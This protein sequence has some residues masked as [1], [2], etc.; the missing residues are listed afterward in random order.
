MALPLIISLVSFPS[1][2]LSLLTCKEGTVGVPTSL[3]WSEGYTVSTCKPG[4]ASRKMCFRPLPLEW[5]PH[6]AG[7]LSVLCPDISPES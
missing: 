3:N 5:G 7:I 6:E 1:Q 4:S 2:R